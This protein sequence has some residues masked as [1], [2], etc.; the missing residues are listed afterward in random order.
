[1]ADT[2]PWLSAFQGPAMQRSQERMRKLVKEG[3]KTNT[4]ISSTCPKGYHGDQAKAV[5]KDVQKVKTR[6]AKSG[7]AGDGYA[8]HAFEKDGKLSDYDKAK[9]SLR[10]MCKA[11]QVKD[12]DGKAIAYVEGYDLSEKIERRSGEIVGK[13]RNTPVGQKVANAR[14]N[15]PFKRAKGVTVVIVRK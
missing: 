15:S 8:R 13:I 9:I 4:T 14:P 3:E 7:Y 11:G 10:H 5:I 6:Y 2:Q 12:L 1:M